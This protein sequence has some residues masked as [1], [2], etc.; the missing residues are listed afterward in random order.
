MMIQTLSTK[1]NRA[2]VTNAQTAAFTLQQTISV[3]PDT[4]NPAF[5]APPLPV[6]VWGAGDGGAL[7]PNRLLLVPFCEGV[8]GAQFSLRLWSWRQVMPDANPQL[9]VWVPIPVLEIACSASNMTGLA[10]QGGGLLG[11]GG[12]SYLSNTEH[13]CDFISI[14]YG[15]LGL[16][17]FISSGAGPGTDLTAFVVVELTGARKYSFDFAQS[18]PVNMNC[19]IA[20]C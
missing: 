20:S 5:A 17:G 14:T 1:F 4:A 2:L 9:N 10:S 3:A 7:A 8:V 13:L 11:A 15:A 12:S 6:G 19:L 18:D 16:T